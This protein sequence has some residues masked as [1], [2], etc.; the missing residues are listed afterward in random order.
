LRGLAPRRPAAAG[1]LLALALVAGI[2]A[3]RAAEPPL[4]PG[5]KVKSVTGEVLQ[6]DT[7]RLRGPVLIDFW[8]TWC[9]PCVASLPEV[10]SLRRRFGPN[11]LTVIGVSVDGPRNFSKVR[12]FAQRL[13]LGFPIVLDEDGSLQQRFQVR[14]IPT[15]VLIS[16]EGRQVRVTQGWRPGETEDMARA[17]ESLIPDVTGPTRP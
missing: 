3:G 5:F 1:L 16:P 13:G 2:G 9:K 15:S 8:A 7:L 17:I 12:P 11:G 14:A 4:A 6:L 10:D